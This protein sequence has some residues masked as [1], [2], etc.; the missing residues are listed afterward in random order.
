MVELYTA[1][2]TFVQRHYDDPTFDGTPVGPAECA[3]RLSIDRMGPAYGA[4]QYCRVRNTTCGMLASR[5]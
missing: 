5:A 2:L 3:L 4:A 1:V